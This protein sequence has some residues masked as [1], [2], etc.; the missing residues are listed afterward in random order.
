MTSKTLGIC[1]AGEGAMGASHA[2][3][4]SSLPGVRL[5]AVVAG[6]AGA[7]RAFADKWRI[8][9]HTLSFDEAIARPDVDAVVVATPSGM[10]ADHAAAA[11]RAGKHVLIEIPV[12]LSLADSERLAQTQRDTGVTMMACHSRRF[13]PPH[14]HLRDRMRA[15]DF[16]LYHLVVETYFMRRTNLNMLGQPRSWV[17]N[18]LW[19]HA[20]HSVDLAAWLLGD[21]DFAS[22]AQA[23]PDHPELGIPMDMSIAM[24][25][26]RDGTLVTMALSFNNEGPFGGFYRYIGEQG[27]FHAWRDEL[28]DAQGNAVPLAGNAFEL[29]DREFVDAIAQ[30]RT[31]ECDIHSVVPS[32][33]LLDALQRSID[34]QR[35]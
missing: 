22:Y 21:A 17:D 16:K 27:T 8:P 35:R 34:A 14:R 26:R 4:L 3:V 28:K 11:A 32:M 29:Q 1:I 12:A 5:A 23:G 25:S 10:H 19:H 7:G 18:L 24:R 15:G 31:P 20:C 6:E 9:F 2:R 30:G 13:G 33:R